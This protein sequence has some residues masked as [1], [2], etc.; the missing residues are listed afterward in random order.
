MKNSEVRQAIKNLYPYPSEVPVGVLKILEHLVDRIE[1]LESK[2]GLVQSEPE[3][4]T[5]ISFKF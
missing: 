5:T 4:I 2:L 1:M 3:M